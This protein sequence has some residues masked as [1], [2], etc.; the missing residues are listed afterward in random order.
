MWPTYIPYA[1]IDLLK[2][3]EIEAIQYAF[4]SIVN[5][6]GIEFNFPHGG[7]QQRAQLMSMILNKKLA[8]GLNFL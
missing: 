2:V 6:F 3:H 4:D 5:D 1:D 7:C 8:K